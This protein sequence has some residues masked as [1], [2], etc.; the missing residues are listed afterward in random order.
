MA[1]RFEEVAEIV[2]I[3]EASACDEIVLET[4]ELKLVVRRR[5]ATTPA[6]VAQPAP[7]PVASPRIEPS[8]APGAGSAKPSAAPLPAKAGGVEMRAPMVGTFYRAPSPDAPPFVEVGS[9][10]QKGDPVCVIEVM[11]LFT[12]VYAEASGL[13][14]YVGATNAELVEY[15]RV[16]FVLEARG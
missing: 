12:T 6:E 10:V 3:I 14:A 11:K 4:P 1:L 15:G 16:L 5:G 8:S 9:T 2:R 13:I 7:S